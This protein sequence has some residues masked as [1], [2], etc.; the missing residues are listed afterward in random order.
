MNP[1]RRDVLVFLLQN[2]NDQ[3]L[4]VHEMLARRRRRR[5]RNIWVPRQCHLSMRGV[6]AIVTPIVSGS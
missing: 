4:H 6:D 2:Q 1:Q 3:L 5:R